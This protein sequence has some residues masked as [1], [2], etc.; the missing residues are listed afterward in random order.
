MIPR[1]TRD[2]WYVEGM[3][4]PRRTDDQMDVSQNL[5][6]DGCVSEFDV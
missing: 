3:G 2:G 5:T 6:Y 1:E 4:D